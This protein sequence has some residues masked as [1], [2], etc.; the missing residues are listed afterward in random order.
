MAANKLAH[1]LFRHADLARGVAAGTKA[2]TVGCSRNNGWVSTVLMRALS[3]QR[4]VH[5]HGQLYAPSSAAHH[6]YLPGKSQV[7]LH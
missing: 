1:A 2:E 3:L 6:C 7:R 5:C 4:M